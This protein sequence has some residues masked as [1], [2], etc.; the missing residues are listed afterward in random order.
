[1]RRLVASVLVLAALGAT[2]GAAHAQRGLSNGTN[3]D[4]VNNAQRVDED[5]L[6]KLEVPRKAGLAAL[7]AGDFVLAEKEFTTLLSNDP[8]TSDAHYLMGLAQLGLEKWA[9]AK[10]SLE[11]AVASEPKRPEPKARLGVANVML[12]NINS[13]ADQHD[14]LSA[15]Y[16][17]CQRC[18]DQK[19]IGDNL[20]ML[21]KLLVAATK[22]KTPG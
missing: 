4:A 18:P 1:M 7:Q 17:E 11:A 21:D 3:F 12:G 22:P 15:M 19:L 8:T 2:A 14:A 13:A 9:D 20:M 16:A 6:R 10:V 5:R